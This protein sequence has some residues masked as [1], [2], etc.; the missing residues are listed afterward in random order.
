[1]LSLFPQFLYYGIQTILVDGA[2]RLGRQLEGNP[3]VFFGQVKAL[4]LQIGQETTLG[5]DV[6]VRNL[7]STD[8][9]FTCNLTYSS[10]D[11]RIYSRKFREAKVREKCGLDKP[12]EIFFKKSKIMLSTELTG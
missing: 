5:L 4:F 6:G 8:R 11:N 10:H 7:V 1:M 9:Y 12:L 2:D 3:F